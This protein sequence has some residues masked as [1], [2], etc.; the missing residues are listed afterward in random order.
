MEF[1]IILVGLLIAIVG[2]IAFAS[3]IQRLKQR[4][5]T[6]EHNDR[7]R[8][9]HIVRQLNEL[10]ETAQQ[11]LEQR[12]THSTSSTIDLATQQA[13]QHIVSLREAYQSQLQ[14]ALQQVETTK[15]Q[16]V[17]EVNCQLAGILQLKQEVEK[18]LTECRQQ[19][20]ETVQQLETQ[21]RVLESPAQQLL[22][23]E[24]ELDLTEIPPSETVCPI[25]TVETPLEPS[26]MAAV[27][28]A[29]SLPEVHFETAFI[30]N[31]LIRRE[32]RTARQFTEL[33]PDD[34]ALELIY[35]PGGTFIMGSEEVEGTTPPHSVS[36]QPFL[37]GKYPVTQAQWEAVMGNN[38]SKF[39]GA[40]LP[41]E[42]VNWRDAVRFCAKLSQL[43]GVHYQL[44]T[45]ARWEYACRAGSMT[46]YSFGDVV[47]PELAN[48]EDSGIKQTSEVGIYPANAFGLYDMHGNVWEWCD[49]TW[50]EDYVDAPNDGTTW[51]GG[52]PQVRLLR[53]G[54]WYNN[55]QKLQSATRIG[56]DISSRYDNEGFR[57]M[58]LLELS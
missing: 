4:L 15:Q 7:L 20:A 5:R 43:T 41:V 24:Q 14:T 12:L 38:P 17:E 35:I 46:R 32:Y 19:L 42:T 40:R 39:R 11:Q 37:A 23:R 58:R 49:D 47:T 9:E 22:N 10:L 13:V 3:T 16:A 51:D 28:F 33:L 30:E 55:G 44:L 57:V 45:E 26:P 56:F 31:H 50:H 54:S 36:L 1:I 48:Y 52:N 21:Q 2:G 27:D 6:L 34:V 8:Q 29:A 18:I 25:L 53:G